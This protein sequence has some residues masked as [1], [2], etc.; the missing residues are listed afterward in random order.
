MKRAADRPTRYSSLEGKLALLL[1]VAAAVAAIVTAVLLRSTESPAA[2]VAIALLV[3][4]PPGVYLVH[5][6]WRSTSS[7]LS[8]LR[9]G[10]GRLKDRD[11]SASLAAPGRDEL[12]ELVA[13]YNALSEVMRD[14]RQTLHQRELLLDTV[15]QATP[16]ALVLTNANARVIYANVSARALFGSGRPLEGHRLEDLLAD[17]PE[18]LREA[19]LRGEDGL[20]TVPMD[21]QSETFH[22]SHRRFTLNAQHHHLYLFKQL[23]HELNR[24]EVA[25]WKK[26][27][28]V[29]SHELNNSLAPLSS[30]A[31]SG[32]LVA[33]NPE[34]AKLELI[35]STIEERALH[36]KRF[37]EGYARFAKLPRPQ[38]ERVEWEPFLASLRETVH[39]ELDGSVPSQPGHFDAGQLEQALINLLKNAH[40]SGSPPGE[41]RLAIDANALG[42]RIQ[43]RDRGGG[44]SQPVLESALL[45]FYST[46]RSGTGLGLPLSREIVEAHG[47]RLSLANRPNGGIEVVLWLPAQPAPTAYVQESRGA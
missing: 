30:L 14:E 8:A 34:R 47:G 44:M 32:K 6:F 1:G 5:R 26:V 7:V 2:A 28:R 15:I 3:V 37:I 33:G 17:V 31:H 22:L 21:G 13:Q 43:V 46:K 12:D 36:L 20:F 29:I 10:M 25:T 42:T 4:L 19:A 41:V 38:P 18:A 23:T 45:P 9:D 39:F 11:F 27:I 24:Q 40:E 16:L 35:F